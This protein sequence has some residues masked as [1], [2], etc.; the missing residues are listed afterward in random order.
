VSRVLFIRISMLGPK[1]VL[2]SGYFDQDE[3]HEALDYEPLGFF[4]DR[5]ALR[6]ER[7]AS[8]SVDGAK[9]ETVGGPA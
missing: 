9:V 8:E 5:I 2:L 3:V 1:G 6:K 4:R 7:L